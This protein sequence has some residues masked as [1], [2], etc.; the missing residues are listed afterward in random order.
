M[1]ERRFPPP[2]IVEDHL[3][4]FIVKDHWAGARA[5]LLRG[6]RAASSGQAAQAQDRNELCKVAR[7][8]EVATSLALALP[9]VGHGKFSLSSSEQQK[10][11]IV[12]ALRVAAQRLLAQSRTTQDQQQSK[13]AEA[14]DNPN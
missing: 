7:A 11:P 14:D 1:A 2:W 10:G 4:C 13:N 9:L 3:A 8:T 5:H 12:G 6:Y